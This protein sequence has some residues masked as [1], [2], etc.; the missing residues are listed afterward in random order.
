LLLILSACKKPTDIEESLNEKFGF[1]SS[2]YNR[3]FKSVLISVD[4]SFIKQNSFIQHYDTLQYFYSSNNYQPV[5]IKSFDDKQLVD[6]LLIILSRAEEHGLNPEHYHFSTIHTEFYKAIDTVQNI[7]RYSHL[8]IAE[9]LVIDAILKY[10][11]HMR[12]GLVNPKI[13]FSGSYFLPIDDSSKG[14]LFQPLSQENILQYLNDI[15]PKSKRYRDLQWVL[16]YYHRFK[17]FDWHHIPI[18][19]KKIELG[20]KDS[21]VALVISRL[22]DLE[23]IDTSKVKFNDLTVYDSL[24]VD[25]VKR[26]QLNNGLVDDGVLGKNTFERLNTTPDQYIDKIKLNLERFRWNDYSDT[27]QFILVNIPDFR[28]FIFDN[29]KKTFN[30]KICCGIKRS[31]YYYEQLKVYKKTKRWKDK[32]DDWETPNMYGEISYLVLNPTWTV[33]PSI[34]RE[35]IAYKLKK[36]S[37]YLRSKNFK[38]YKDGVEI[39]PEEVQL[40]ELHSDVIPYRIVQDPGAGN[41][42]GKI[43]FMFNNPFGIYLHDTPTRSP[44]NYSNRAVSHGC[45]RVEKPLPIAEFLLRN[46]PSWNINYLKIEI[47]Q[48]VEDKSIVSEYY[49]KRSSLRKYAS[50][51]QTTDVI[52]SQK[53]PVYIDY[54]TAWVDDEGVIN[55]REDVYNRD[56]VLLE[57]L[58]ANKLL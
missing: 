7:L 22:I 40:T 53:T 27:S 37:T 56:K 10:S 8:A 3:V 46:H 18:P 4:S 43:K 55:F 25:Y 1:S 48:K 5:F 49:K 32:P 34:M 12:Y 24:L 39:S 23:Y 30:S 14:D 50:I 52:L 31:A 9:L 35:E 28:L 42:L 36:D 33:P 2:D 11:S 20:A 41:A 21:S 51:G 13:I 57:Y 38:V 45:V 44:F 19:A 6:S 54:Y 15:Q 16:K 58:S 26:F 17:E 29:G 47:G